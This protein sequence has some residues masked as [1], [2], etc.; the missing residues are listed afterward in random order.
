VPYTFVYIGSYN[1]IEL[2]PCVFWEL[3]TLMGPVDWLLALGRTK[4]KTNKQKIKNTH[5]LECG[6]RRKSPGLLPCRSTGQNEIFTR[7]RT[8]FNPGLPRDD[9]AH[10]VFQCTFVSRRMYFGHV[11]LCGERREV[12]VAVWLR[13]PG[14]EYTWTKYSNASIYIYIYVNIKKT[15]KA[16]TI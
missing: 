16:K 4:H 13:F 7:I 6:A 10:R 8:G 11:W 2:Q 9:F 1:Y 14:N 5:T 3:K 12:Q 15:E